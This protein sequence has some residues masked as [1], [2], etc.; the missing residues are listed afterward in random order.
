[1]GG[2]MGPSQRKNLL[3][4]ILRVRSQVPAPAPA[5]RWFSDDTSRG[6]QHACIV[7]GRVIFSRRG[8]RIIARVDHSLRESE[9]AGLSPRGGGFGS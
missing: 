9:V 1:M 7:D 3:G 6:P 4:D 2:H 8:F 5:N